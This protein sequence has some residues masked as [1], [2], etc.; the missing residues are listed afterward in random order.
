MPEV[1]SKAVEEFASRHSREH[2]TER[3]ND[4]DEGAESSS[5]IDSKPEHLQ[6]LS[7]PNDDKW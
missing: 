1:N 6:F 5:S 2:V 3:L 7:L 4:V